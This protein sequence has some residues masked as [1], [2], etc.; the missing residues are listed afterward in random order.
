M[1]NCRIAGASLL[2]CLLALPVSVAAD[3]AT[4]E[5]RK[6]DFPRWTSSVRGGAVYQFD[7][8][9]DDGGEYESGRYNLS[10]SHGYSTSYRDGVSLGL[11]YSYDDYS[12]S[13]GT[14]DSIAGQSPWESVHTISISTPVRKS[15]GEK[16]SGFFIPSIRSTGESSAQ[17]SR[18]VTG[19]VFGGASYTFGRNL[20]LGPGIGLVTQLE[21]SATVFPVLIVDWKITKKLS[22]ET[23]RGLAAT[24]GP[25]LTLNYQ[26]TPQYRLDFGGRYEKLRFRLDKN[27]DV[28]GG[29]G[30]ETSIPIFVS[31]TYAP[32]RQTSLSL[33]SGVEFDP[34][35]KVE[36]SKGHTLREE[37]GDP[38]IF[39]G[40]TFSK[41]F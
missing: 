33:V 8:S 7:A 31:F 27:G 2:C 32:S 3:T 25:G 37:S 9:L 14:E 26:A 20:T 39:S 6:P 22:L 10:V 40:L 21:E 12:F 29:I 11:S 18:T 1:K 17:F 5:Q 15:L 4:E 35:L 34:T 23:G 16:W 30:E 19:G 38:G 36:N 28:P 13:G 24:L 41:R